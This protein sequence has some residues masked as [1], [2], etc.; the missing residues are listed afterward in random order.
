MHFL[1][2][3]PQW[4]YVGGGQ[5]RSNSLAS[6]C[7]YV[8]R[9]QPRALLL[10]FPS[11]GAVSATGKRNRPDTVH[12]PVIPAL[13]VAEAEGPPEPRNFKSRLDNIRKT[14]SQKDLKITQGWWRVPVVSAAGEAEGGGPL[15][16][17]RSRLQ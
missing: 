15:G 17:G 16:P 13:W 1:T 3:L 11:V 5:W 9:P 4:G 7:P 14:L 12:M 6:P 8:S 10:A 2:W